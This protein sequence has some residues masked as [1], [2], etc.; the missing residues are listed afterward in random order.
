VLKV[1]VGDYRKYGFPLPDHRIFD[2]HPTINSELLHYVKHGRIRPRPDIAR[3]AGRRVHFVDGTSD[4]F[5]LVVSATGFHVSF[6]FLP[7]GL[8]PVKGS[9]ALLYAGVVL[10]EQKNLYIVG[11]AQVRYGFGPLVTP[12]ADL[13]AR[14]IR[15][16]DEMELPLGLVLKEAGYK[17][18]TTHLIDPHG[19]L[20]RMRLAPW[21]FPLLRWKERRLRTKYGRASAAAAPPAAVTSAP[22]NPKLPVNPNLE[23]Y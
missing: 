8:V 20:R 4:E 15:M 7:P 17:L 18:P 3:Y 12:G 22:A 14:M 1:I 10:P 5:D 9:I 6:P 11:T 21:L 23:V 16:Q 19:A 2:A 13:I